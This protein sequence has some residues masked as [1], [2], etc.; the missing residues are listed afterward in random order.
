MT[1]LENTG[2]SLCW[3]ERNVVVCGGAGDRCGLKIP[4]VDW[5]VAAPRGPVSGEPTSSGG[6]VARAQELHRVGNDIDCLTFGALLGLP[7]A[8]FEPPVDRDR[9]PLG[10]V[11]RRVL[12]LRAP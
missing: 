7:L 10:Q 3:L 12:A 8:P 6:V 4:F 2:T 1:G 11:A 5:D 9:A